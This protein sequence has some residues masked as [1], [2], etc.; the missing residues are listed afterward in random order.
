M[1][2]QYIWGT[3]NRI[4]PEAP[5]PVVKMEREEFRL[6]GAANVAANINML[7]CEALPVGLVGNC[8]SGHQILDILH[9]A[10][11]SHDGV[12]VSKDFQTVV[13]Q[14]IITDQ[15]QLLRL[16]Y[17]SLSLDLQS[18]ENQLIEKVK[19]LLPKV[20]GV[21]ISDYAKGTISESLLAETV[22]EAAFRKIPIVCDPAKGRPFEQYK[23][24]TAIKP[25]RLE[26]EEG[27]L[28]KL[29]DRE[30]VLAAAAIIKEKSGAKFLTIS[31][32]KDG[33][34]FYRDSSQYNFLKTEAPEV[35]D[36]NG[37]GDTF[38]SVLVVLLANGVAGE[39]A[40]Q[41][42]NIAGGLATSH[43][44]VV[45]IPWSDILAHLSSDN[46]SRK[47]TTLERLKQEITRNRHQP[48]IFTNGYFDNISAGH[49]RFLQEIGHIKG[50]LVV[51]INSDQS[52]I[53][54][55][56]SAPLLAE[57]DRAR[58]LA[59][60]EN[61]AKVIIF[62]DQDA[63]RLI[64]ELSPDIVVKGEAFKGKKLPEQNAIDKTGARIEFI[65]HF[66]W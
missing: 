46:L 17:E 58:L 61:V 64:R 40:S 41:I 12:V 66:S 1:L 9:K 56:G 19:L 29:N 52:I 45:A 43:L 28:V 34:L 11:I 4:S 36:T 15:Q 31:L 22:H 16:D 10:G 54:Q 30:S 27:T 48:L 6:G 39:I 57:Q 55:K 53:Q 42:A 8:Q 49:L 50:S 35:H 51:A 20:D 44:G 3:V 62:D 38:V 32:D 7:D 47:I 26:T 65:Q 5:I 60:I 25:N 63:S 14:R 21:I 23:N 13:K 37:A 33:V 59:S 18:F 2:D 24:V